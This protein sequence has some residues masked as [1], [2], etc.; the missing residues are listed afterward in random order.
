MSAPSEVI[1]LAAEAVG[2][3]SYAR[4]TAASRPKRNEKKSRRSGNGPAPT[5]RKTSSSTIGCSWASKT[6][7]R[8]T[9]LK[10]VRLLTSLHGY[11]RMMRQRSLE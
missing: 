4:G 2:F 6:P 11:L 1:R 10:R 9:R 3:C 5:C 8:R 7:V